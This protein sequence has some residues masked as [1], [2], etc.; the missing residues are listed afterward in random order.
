MLTV[1]K[2]IDFLYDHL[3]KP[4]Y[5]ATV[6]NLESDLTDTFCTTVTF[7]GKR[8]M[9]FQVNIFAPNEQYPRELIRRTVDGSVQTTASHP[10]GLLGISSSEVKQTVHDYLKDV[11]ANNP[12]FIQSE[13]ETTT[14][15]NSVLSRL[16]NFSSCQEGKS[17]VDPNSHQYE[18]LLI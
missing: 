11:L 14:A 3:E 9:L 16:F 4:R 13:Q 7:D 12:P 18:D 15:V 17:D 6:H 8:S 5:E 1:G 10:V 2:Y